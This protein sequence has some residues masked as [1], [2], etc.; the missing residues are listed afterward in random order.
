MT[1]SPPA[2]SAKTAL[3]ALAAALDP[4]RYA[5]DL[6][7]GDGPVPYLLVANRYAP[8]AEAIYAGET[9]Y[10]WPWDQPI[11]A[12]GNPQAAAT[13]VAAVLAATPEPAAHG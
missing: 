13:K 2:V 9:F 1:T 10:H 3:Y 11:A 4:G 8:L 6:V 5:T 12:I 7:T